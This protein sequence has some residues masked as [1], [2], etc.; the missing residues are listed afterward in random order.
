MDLFSSSRLPLTPL[1][2]TNTPDMRIDSPA[3]L[4][5]PTN[6]FDAIAFAEKLSKA[7]SSLHDG[8]TDEQKVEQANDADETFYHTLLELVN[9]ESGYTA[10]LTDLVE[11]SSFDLFSALEA[12]YFPLYPNGD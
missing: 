7:G 11:V 2:E 1:E 10:D 5:E 8:L 3:D 9:S 4:A 6:P 12:R